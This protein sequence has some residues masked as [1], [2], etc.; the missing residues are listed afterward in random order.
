MAVILDPK[1][2]TIYQQVQGAQSRRGGVSPGG[3]GGSGIARAGPGQV[4]GIRR[5]EDHRAHLRARAPDHLPRAL[6]GRQGR[7]PHQPRLPRPV[8][9]RHRGLQGRA[10][11]PPVRVP[12]HHQVP[13]V[14]A[15][16]QECADRHADR[17]WQGWIRLRPEGQVEQRD[18]AVLP[19]LHDRALSAPRRVHR[20]S[21]GRH[22]R[23]GPRTRLH[24]RAIQD[25]S[26]TATNPPCSPARAPAGADR[27]CAPRRPATAPS[28]SC[29]RC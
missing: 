4:P 25:V 6:A 18:H 11:V 12:R 19:E 15:D 17:R 27:W 23:R 2:E 29:A 1:I 10:A 5:A 7:G 16:L 22:R 8:Q 20:R 28:T 9:Q 13:R 3:E 21:R 26:P 24:V 14:R